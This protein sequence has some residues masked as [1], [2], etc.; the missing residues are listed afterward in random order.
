[1]T[2][3]RDSTKVLLAIIPSPLLGPIEI[4][5][6]GH[7]PLSVVF[8]DFPHLTECLL[9]EAYEVTSKAIERQ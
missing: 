8:L 3:L 2:E 1:M 5:D 6:A 7:P 4:Q 9:V